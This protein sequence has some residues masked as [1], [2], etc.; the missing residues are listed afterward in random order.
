[1][2]LVCVDFTA[3]YVPGIY[4]GTTQENNDENRRAAGSLDYDAKQE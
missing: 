1:M 3:S 2:P 4:L